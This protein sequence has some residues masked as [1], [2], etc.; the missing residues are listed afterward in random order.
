MLI[1]LRIFCILSWVDLQFVSIFSTITKNLATFTIELNICEIFLAFFKRLQHSRSRRK[2]HNCA[3]PLPKSAS[4]PMVRPPKL[5]TEREHPPQQ[6]GG[7][8]LQPSAACSNTQIRAIGQR[9]AISKAPFD[10]LTVSNTAVHV[11]MKCMNNSRI[12]SFFCAVLREPHSES[13]FALSAAYSVL[14][15]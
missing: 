2:I 10:T 14:R 4:K 11:K 8:S 5:P 7:C 6:C 13:N 15:A 9:A 1:F 3:F 12:H